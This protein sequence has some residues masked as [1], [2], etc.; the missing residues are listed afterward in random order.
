MRIVPDTNVLVS[1]AFTKTGPPGRVVELILNG[2]INAV[3]DDRI[4]QEYQEVLLRPKLSIDPME[5]SRLLD[6]F[7]AD[8]EWVDTK[9][10]HAQL[11]D[12]DDQM[13]LEVAITADA[14]GIIT[15]NRRHFPP[16]I[17]KPIRIFSPAEF[18]EE[19]LKQL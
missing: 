12:V 17:C 8:T 2:K 16:G 4:F 10:I 18:I 15:G 14:D 6:Y 7:E 3:I 1:A 11:P 19:Y 9:E 13:F 5:V